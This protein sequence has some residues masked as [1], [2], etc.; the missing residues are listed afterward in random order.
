MSTCPSARSAIRTF[1]RA[2]SGALTALPRF[3]LRRAPSSWTAGGSSSGTVAIRAPN[4]RGRPDRGLRLS[5]LL[6][7]GQLAHCGLGVGRPH[8]DLA[9]QHGVDA[10]LLELLD[11]V[12]AGYP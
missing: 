1:R 6:R 7:A 10:R 4:G 12:A 2:S 8:Q 9:D 3:A 5:G 11:L